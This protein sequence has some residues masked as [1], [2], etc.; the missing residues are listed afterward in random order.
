MLSWVSPFNQIRIWCVTSDIGCSL[1]PS[2]PL[3]C[4]WRGFC[5]AGVA[6]RHILQSVLPRLSVDAIGRDGDR[7]IFCFCSAL[8]PLM[9]VQRGAPTH[10]DGYRADLFVFCYILTCYLLAVICH[11]CFVLIIAWSV[12]RWRA[13]MD[14]FGIIA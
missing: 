14:I 3:R 5:G 4:C 12:S 10:S 13:G 2:L 7:N 11:R 8:T 9:P 1:C 6:I